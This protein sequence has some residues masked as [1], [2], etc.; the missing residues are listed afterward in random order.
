MD[1]ST[2]AGFGYTDTVAHKFGLMHSYEHNAL[3]SYE[4][5]YNSLPSGIFSL[6]VL[7][8]EQ[9]RPEFIM[10]VIVK[11]EVS[12]I[13][14]IDSGDHRTVFVETFLKTV[15]SKH[16]Q[17]RLNRRLTECGFMFK[18][19]D[20]R[21]AIRDLYYE[22]MNPQVSSSQ[23]DASKLDRTLARELLD[24]C[25]DVRSLLG[26][27]SSPGMR[28]ASTH[29]VVSFVDEDGK[30]MLA[31]LARPQT[32]GRDST[33]EDD[34]IAIALVIAEVLLDHGVPEEQFLLSGVGDDWTLRVDKKYDYLHEL[35]AERF[36][37][38][39]LKMKMWR[40]TPTSFHFLGADIAWTKDGYQPVW[41]LERSAV[42]LAYREKPTRETDFIYAMRIVSILS[43]NVYHPKR[44]QMYE[45]L[46]WFMETHNVKASE[47][48]IVLRTLEN[49]NQ[50]YWR[51]DS[52]PGGPNLDTLA[53]VNKAK[54]NKTMQSLNARFA[55]MQTQLNKKG[56]KP[57]PK[58]KANKKKPKKM[59]KP[60]GGMMEHVGH[61]LTEGEECG[62]RYGLALAYPFHPDA[63]GAC[64]PKFP[65]GETQKFSPWVKGTFVTN[66]AGDG[67][68]ACQPFAFSDNTAGLH[69]CYF[70]S[71]TATYVSTGIPASGAVGTS[72]VGT[73]APYANGQIGVSNQALKA[74]LV[75]CGLRV[76]YLGRED[77]MA[78]RVLLVM[79]RDGEGV[80]GLVVS[81]ILARRNSVSFP[82]SRD[83]IHAIWAPQDTGDFD[84]QTYAF[85]SSFQTGGGPTNDVMGFAV[86]GGPAST[87]F[88]FEFI[89]HEEV[90]GLPSDAL[91]SPN[92][93]VNA[94]TVEALQQV[95]ISISN[96]PSPTTTPTA[97]ILA[98]GRAYYEQVSDIV[99]DKATRSIV[100]AVWGSIIDSFT[101][102]RVDTIGAGRMN[103][104]ALQL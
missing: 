48:S 38:H 88:E 75:G 85:P 27:K 57:N 91:C 26:G 98:N 90:S 4:S 18:G 86:T 58:K 7:T 77:A 37:T 53:M 78:G 42:R 97:Q 33:T 45:Y 104:A 76:R 83:W 65:C 64:V 99:N 28:F 72:T 101:G 19:H 40:V 21:G 35:I 11:E 23:G 93:P 66:A 55:A 74:R 9:L 61:R 68:I 71:N 69:A 41:D 51:K 60:K 63:I 6:D 22:C 96:S 70:S 87:S 31:K 50:Y 3:D 1:M 84:M 17:E 52:T 47:K 54:Q 5:W 14:K 13:E 12:K 29:P 81:A 102:Y 20:A 94:A 30:L 16:E 32:S 59:K 39:G 43:F 73:N 89:A 44:Q 79:S 80:D 34:F 62:W 103:A 2:S 24:Q 10:K 8:K 15:R 67:F 46:K 95:A 36:A 92:H 56:G 25:F 49:A 100:G 82:I